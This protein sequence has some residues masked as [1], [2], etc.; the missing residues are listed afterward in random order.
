MGK[1]FKDGVKGSAFYCTRKGIEAL[2][3]D[4]KGKTDLKGLMF[5]TLLNLVQYDDAEI[6]MTEAKKVWIRNKCKITS[7]QEYS[8]VLKLLTAVDVILVI[9]TK[10]YMINPSFAW[11]GSIGKK[12]EAESKYAIM[13]SIVNNKRSKR[14]V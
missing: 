8:R 6:E 7:R 3:T 14:I 1:N 12:K 11:Y 2:L 5:S 9:N 4:K 13:S 10:K